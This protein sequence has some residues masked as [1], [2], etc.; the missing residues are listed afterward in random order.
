MKRRLE[1]TQA[2]LKAMHFA[3]DMHKTTTRKGAAREP[4]VNHVIE[5]AELLARIGGVT[6]PA[7]LQAAILH[8]IVE[9]TPVTFADVE[10]AFGRDVRHIVEEVTDDKSLLKAER[11]QLQIDK[12]PHLSS[13]A[14]MIKIADKTSNVQAIM[15]S[16]P[17]DWSR[18]RRL[19]YVE[20]S[21]AVV[22]GCRGSNA[23]LEQY[24]DKVVSEC[25]AAL[26]GGDE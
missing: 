18:E 8:D 2:L 15:L 1:P 6:D 7:T 4:Y 9:D 19:E 10:R 25:R 11:K 14:K 22:A 3:A 24:Y 20:W 17:A 16:P 23:R 12:A 26:A 13:A 21:E 5:V